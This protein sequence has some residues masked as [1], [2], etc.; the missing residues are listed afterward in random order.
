MECPA[1]G[2][3]LVGDF[4]LVVCPAS[5]KVA[6][7]F[8]VEEFSVGACPVDLAEYVPSVGVLLERIAL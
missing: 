1:S 3:E 5:R 2:E 8:P 7:E 4:L 6:E